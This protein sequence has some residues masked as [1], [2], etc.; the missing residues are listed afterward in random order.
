MVLEATDSQDQDKVTITITIEIP[1]SGAIVAT[2][3]PP[4]PT[5]NTKI[6]AGMASRRRASMGMEI[7][8]ATT[9]QI[10]TITI[11]DMAVGAVEEVL[12]TETEKTVKD[13]TVTIDRK[14]IDKKGN[15]SIII[16]TT[17]IIEVTWAKE[18]SLMNMS[19][20]ITKKKEITTEAK[21]IF[22]EKIETDIRTIIITMLLKTKGKLPNWPIKQPTA[23]N[24]HKE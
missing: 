23:S 24:N 13:R 14:N 10:T 12:V 6:N 22:V 4:N 16:E 3:K 7:V 17:T 5:T 18:I 2:D 9:T 21:M 19:T 11:T 1:L 15:S 20:D 8:V